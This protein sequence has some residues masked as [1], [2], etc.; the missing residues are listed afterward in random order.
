MNE[1]IRGESFVFFLL[2]VELGLIGG[3]KW[4]PRG[5]LAAERGQTAIY[6]CEVQ[7]LCVIKIVMVNDGSSAF[8]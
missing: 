2:R 7:R 5:S 3:V 8:F 4:L 6:K 1:K